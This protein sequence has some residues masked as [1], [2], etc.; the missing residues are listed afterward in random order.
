[1]FETFDWRGKRKD[2][3]LGWLIPSWFCFSGDFL[4]CFGV[5]L[6]SILGLLGMI[7]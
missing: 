3:S 6:S 1:M 7:F 5:F 2:V 4:I